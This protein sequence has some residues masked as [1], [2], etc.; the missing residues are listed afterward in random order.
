M[1]EL[2]NN[3][4]RFVQNP[5]GV[6][7]LF[8]TALY[9]IASMLF[10]SAFDNLQGDKERL[11]VI[12]FVI[13]FPI[14]MFGTFVWLVVKH[15]HKLYSPGDFKDEKW[16][17]VVNGKT[18]T[19]GKEPTAIKKEEKIEISA[20]VFQNHRNKRNTIYN[21]IEELALKEL[22]EEEKFVVKSQ[23]FINNGSNRFEFDGYAEKDGKTCLIEIKRL[24][25]IKYIH[26]IIQ[27]LY[28][29]S[30]VISEIGNTNT[31]FYIVFII[32][33]IIDNTEKTSIIALL[34]KELSC[35]FVCKFYTLKEIGIDEKKLSIN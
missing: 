5:L 13:L 17:A 23:A 22:S 21:D 24:H 8:V 19:P 29:Q 4:K 3:I 18:F 10:S 31:V 7:A 2:T 30:K 33:D 1:N 35:D 11:P 34:E 9:G 32:D 28:K 16:F 14:I 15:N 12:W 6:I 26:H 20:P 27:M 25:S